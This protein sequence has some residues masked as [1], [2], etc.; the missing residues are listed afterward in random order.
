MLHNERSPTMLSAVLSNGNDINNINDITDDFKTDTGICGIGC[1]VGVTTTREEKETKNNHNDIMI[2]NN[3]NGS[4]NNNSMDTINTKSNDSS[5]LVARS[6]TTSNKREKY[7][8]NDSI[9][10]LSAASGISGASTADCKNTTMSGTKYELFGQNPVKWIVSLWTLSRASTMIKYCLDLLNSESLNKQWY[11]KNEYCIVAQ[12]KMDYP[13]EDDKF[14][15]NVN[16]ITPPYSGIVFNGDMDNPH[17]HHN[18]HNHKNN[19][20]NRNRNRNTIAPREL[21]NENLISFNVTNNDREAST[22]DSA[23]N[24]KDTRTSLLSNTTV[25]TGTGT[26]TRSSL[27]IEQYHKNCVKLQIRLYSTIVEA[28]DCR[29]QLFNLNFGDNTHGHHQN[30]SNINSNVGLHW[31]VQ[32]E[33]K[34]GIMDNDSHH[35]A[36]NN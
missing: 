6:V 36:S 31:I 22:P 1:S 4:S 19:N 9:C 2:N 26:S 12:T 7:N 24:R 32:N 34:P 17:D 29:S 20:T 13:I 8:D 16:D 14:N 15:D 21:N 3:N 23:H 18:H 33:M 10:G 28:N 30:C 5:S 11:V 27:S 35:H 25:S